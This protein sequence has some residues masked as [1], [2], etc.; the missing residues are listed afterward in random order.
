MNPV[1]S[2][3]GRDAFLDALNDSS[4][5]LHILDKEP[6]TLEDGLN[7]ASRIEAYI[8]SDVNAANYSEK[9]HGRNRKH[10]RAVID[11]KPAGDNYD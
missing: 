4:L 11:P 3:I 5:R 8:K 1:V 2:L 10:V 9:D 7:I 6:Q